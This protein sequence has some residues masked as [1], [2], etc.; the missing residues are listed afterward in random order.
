ML[1]LDEGFPMLGYRRGRQISDP[2]ERRRRGLPKANDRDAESGDV[3]RSV[4]LDDA[5]DEADHHAVRSHCAVGDRVGRGEKVFERL[6][7]VR[8]AVNEAALVEPPALVELRDRER[9]YVV[10]RLRARSRAPGQ[11]LARER[12]ALRIDSAGR[13]EPRANFFQHSHRTRKS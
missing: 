7:A 4:R 8:L 12:A 1:L 6:A 13:E 5:D 3:T 11:S 10:A 9:A 2:I